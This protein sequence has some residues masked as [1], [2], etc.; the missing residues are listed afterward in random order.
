MS[1]DSLLSFLLGAL[2]VAQIKFGGVLLGSDLFALCVV[3]LYL[4]KAKR[5]RMLGED[6]YLLYGIGLWFLGAVATDIYRA[7]PVEDF[8]RGWAKLVF[9]TLTIMALRLLSA[10]KFEPLRAAA[11]GG[12][13]GGLLQDAFF[14]NEYQAG[15]LLDPTSWKFGLG[16]LL[17][18]F[19]A[20]LGTYPAIGRFFGPLGTA[21][22]LLVMAGANLM[23][24][25]RSMFGIAAVAALYSLLK[26]ALDLHP[27][28]KRR[29]SPGVFAM[30]GVLGLAGAQGLMAL[31][32]FAAGSGALGVE[33]KEKYEWQTSGDLSLLQSGRVES[34]VSLQAIADSPV[35][36]HGSW[37]R[38]MHYVMLLVDRLDAAGM[39][40]EGDPFASDLIPSHSHLFGAWVEAGLLGGVFWIG[41]LIAGVMAL[42]RVLKINDPPISLVALL[43]FD[44]LWTILFSPF[45]LDQRFWTSL[46]ISIVL[47]VLRPRER[48]DE[49]GRT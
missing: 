11:L 9:F 2:T 38:D 15:G 43:L 6:R 13:L 41:V 29:L 37:A 10:G 12:V 44:L 36:G 26:S 34:L 14:P 48:K 1:I 27:A 33:A 42:Y 22:P 23:M 39:K 28:T 31:Y 32:G 3:P 5:R 18:I 30:L 47:W 35:L 8:T 46:K 40:M 19:A 25:A 17:T 49:K 45:G 16:P 24:N 20:A 4:L 7:T 21:G